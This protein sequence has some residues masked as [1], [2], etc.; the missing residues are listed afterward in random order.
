[1]NE[2]T[3]VKGDRKN[4]HTMQDNILKW[5]SST[6]NG[7]KLFFVVVYKEILHLTRIDELLEMWEYDF[8]E[9]TF[10]KLAIKDDVLLQLPEGYE[11]RYNLIT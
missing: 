3:N 10:P 6:K 11:K 5:T 9:N 8:S 1:M 4:S 7:I 2:K